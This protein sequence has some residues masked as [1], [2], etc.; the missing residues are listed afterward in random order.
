MKNDTGYYIGVNYGTLPSLVAKKRTEKAKHVITRDQCQSAI[1]KYL[2]SGGKITKLDTPDMTNHGLLD[3]V[4][5]D[6]WLR[7]K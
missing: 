4:D 1:S 7:E 2:A 6:W 5:A 3:H